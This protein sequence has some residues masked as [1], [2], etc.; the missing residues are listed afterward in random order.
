[1]SRDYVVMEANS[2]NEN[3]AERVATHLEHFTVQQHRTAD[4]HKMI[5]TDESVLTVNIA[6]YFPALISA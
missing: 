4:T 3:T 2:E 1:M 5:F 6:V